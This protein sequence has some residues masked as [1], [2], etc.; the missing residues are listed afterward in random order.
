MS[1]IV[2]PTADSRSAP[3]ARITASGQATPLMAAVLVVAGLCMMGL[4]ALTGRL[5]DRA[6]ADSAA[7]AAALAG[8][9]GGPPMAARVAQANGATLL[10]FR[11]VDGDAVVEVEVHG[12]RSVSRARLVV[13]GLAQPRAEAR[14]DASDGRDAGQGPVVP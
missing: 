11:W 9:E 12:S 2:A 1:A 8:V 13:P 6:R 4:V 10:S 7:D 3:P 5:V 14:T